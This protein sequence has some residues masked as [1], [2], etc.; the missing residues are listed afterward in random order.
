MLIREIEKKDAKFCF[1]LDS[2]TISIWSK[3]QWLR[4]IQKDNAKVFGIWLSDTIVGICAFQIVLDEAQ[5]NFF[6]INQKFQRKGLGTYLMN[7]LIKECKK[8]KINRM[9][10][11]VSDSN[12]AALN[13]Y[14]NFDFH[15]VGVR[16]KYYKDG[17]NS[18]LK[19][20][21]LIKK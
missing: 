9:L 13:F 5:I 3:Q 4:E 16:K 19:E 12:L 8:S 10:L 18:L 1:E 11:E 7:F 14:D 21:K 2:K 20:K 6:S 17:C 15:T